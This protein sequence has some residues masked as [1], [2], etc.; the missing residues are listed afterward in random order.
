MKNLLNCYIVLNCI[1]TSK[2]FSHKQT[3]KLVSFHLKK[4]E[5]VLLAGKEKKTETGT[6]KCT[7]S[8]ANT[9]HPF[10]TIINNDQF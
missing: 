4:R 2:T 1:N 5:F 6:I 8:E 7:S 9:I 3:E 10:K